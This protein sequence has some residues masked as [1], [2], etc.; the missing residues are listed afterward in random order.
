[1]ILGRTTW[2]A[3]GTTDRDILPFLPDELKALIEPSG[4]FILHYGAIHFRGC[5]FEPE[6]NSLREICWGDGSLRSFYPSVGIDDIPFAQDQVGD[7]YLLRF[8]EVFHLDAETGEIG[9][10]AKSLGEFLAGIEHDIEDYLNVSLGYPLD[11]GTGL[12][13]YP[14]FCVAESSGQHSS[15]TP[16]PIDELLRFHA[17]FA[18]QI[19]KVPDG[20]QI[21]IELID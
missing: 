14:P 21:Q 19:A 3:G 9:R 11:P 17:D 12:H 5:A 7:Q 13:A 18:R 6:W 15:L 10:F 4:G 2:Q 16:V 1:M 8:D 20:G